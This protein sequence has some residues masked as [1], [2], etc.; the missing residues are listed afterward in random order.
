MMLAARRACFSYQDGVAVHYIEDG[1]AILP[2]S[3]GRELAL[4]H[5]RAF[6][7]YYRHASRDTVSNTLPPPALTSRPPSPMPPP[8]RLATRRRIFT[9][10]DDGSGCRLY[11]LHDSL[12]ALYNSSLPD[13]KTFYINLRPADD[14]MPQR[15]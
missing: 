1:W 2:F 11:L 8:G 10:F 4:M 9:T 13:E 3:H 5:Q 12:R 7:P 15:A 6:T 14:V